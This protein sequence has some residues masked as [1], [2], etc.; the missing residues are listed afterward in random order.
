MDVV[1]RFSL[2]ATAVLL[3]IAVMLGSVNARPALS[4]DAATQ[5]ARAASYF[6]STAVLAR[7]ARR[8]APWGEEVGVQE[9]AAGQL[10]HPQDIR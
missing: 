3:G 1:R 4:A 9:Y 8:E 5:L 2:L 7:N 10:R 6:D